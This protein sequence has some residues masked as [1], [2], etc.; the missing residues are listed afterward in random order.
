MMPNENIFRAVES[1]NVAELKKIF[2]EGG[3]LN[4]TKYYGAKSLKLAVEKENL[5]ILK[6]LFES[7]KKCNRETFWN[8]YSDFVLMN[9]VIFENIEMLELLFQYGE[10]GENDKKYPKSPALY[11]AVWYENLQIATLL[12]KYNIGTSKKN[13]QKALLQAMS[14]KNEDLIKLMISTGA[15]FT[16]KE[17]EILKNPVIFELLGALNIY[18][19]LP[20]AKEIYEKN[21]FTTE[22]KEFLLSYSEDFES[23]L[24]HIEQ[25]KKQE[26]KETATEI[27]KVTVSN[28]EKKINSI[29]RELIEFAKK[30]NT[31][32]VKHLCKGISNDRIIAAFEAAL[33]KGK[34]S[35]A[36]NIMDCFFDQKRDKKIYDDCLAKLFITSS[37]L[38]DKEKM[39]FYLEKIIPNIVWK[40]ANENSKSK[41]EIVLEKGPQ[42]L[43]EILANYGISREYLQK[44]F[45][46]FKKINMSESQLSQN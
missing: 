39:I 26:K 44:A 22:M 6:I 35:T 46:Y 13:L 17:T 38:D 20:K 8:R 41:L 21:E 37:Y 45:R 23:L 14:K 2:A 28:S 7:K 40:S 4:A 19:N 10:P 42:Y 43:Y 16:K 24:F 18:N 36:T 15:K 1:G 5:E 11:Y 30:G 25:N 9:A 33:E 29:D 31:K 32:T 3:K 34:F 12:I 27:K